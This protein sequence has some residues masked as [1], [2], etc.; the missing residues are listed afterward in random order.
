V[1]KEVL[2]EMKVDYK[3]VE[4]EA[5]FYGPKV[6]GQFTTAVGRE[7]TLSTVQLDFAAKGRFGLKYVDSDGKENEE[8]FVIHRA[9][10]STHE[11]LIAFLIEHYA[12]AWPMWMAPV[13][14]RLLS[15]G[16]GHVEFANELATE[17]K[18]SGVRV[19]VDDG[20]DTVG[21][22]IRKAAGEKIPWTIVLGDKEVAG[23]PFK[24]RV[25]G[26]ELELELKREELVEQIK[27]E[28]KM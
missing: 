14:I 21:N 27:E 2:D 10:V 4:D 26:Q 18:D 25:F 8:V 19:E 24:V 20:D 1:I 28:S 22:K 9:P 16:E 17:L 23:E 7:E 5:A 12:G 15:V 6:D 11:R 13:Q 3:E